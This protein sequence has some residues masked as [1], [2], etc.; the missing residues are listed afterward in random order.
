MR[1][2]LEEVLGDQP[3]TYEHIDKLPYNHAVRF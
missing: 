1:S 2:E 3:V